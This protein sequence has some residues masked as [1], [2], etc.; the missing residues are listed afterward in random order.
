MVESSGKLVGILT[1]R[2]M[3]FEGSASA[4][5]RD[6]MTREGLITVREGVSQDAARALLRQH[7][8]ER[9]IVVDDDY[10]AVG[11]ITVKDM[12]KAEAHPAAAKDS[13]GRRLVGAASTVGDA[14]FERSMALMEAGV[15]VVVIDTAHGHSKQVGDAVE[16]VPPGS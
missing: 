2:D 8:I 14:G 16:A 12:E 6:L 10:R 5:A 13:R 15:D 11:L 4:L 9:L 7:K 3:R 1:N